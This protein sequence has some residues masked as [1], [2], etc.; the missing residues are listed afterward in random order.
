M[1]APSETQNLQ[2]MLETLDTTLPASSCP[3]FKEVLKKFIASHPKGSA[4]EDATQPG[5]PDLR[6]PPT[7]SL[8]LGDGGVSSHVAGG[9]EATALTTNDTITFD[10]IKAGDTSLEVWSNSLSHWMACEVKA[11]F[12]TAT[13]DDSYFAPA[14]SIKVKSQNGIKYIRE[15]MF[16]ILLRKKHSEVK[17]GLVA[18]GP[19]PHVVADSPERAAQEPRCLKLESSS[20]VQEKLPPAIVVPP[21][22]QEPD[23]PPSKRPKK[24]SSQCA[25]DFTLDSVPG[26]LLPYIE[27]LVPKGPS[28]SDVTVKCKFEVCYSIK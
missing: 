19:G 28:P 27:D 13:E 22:P 6:G 12:I 8:P 4:S 10:S 11:V 3:L 14:R 17:K 15:P 9:D 5:V 2:A 23:V 7:A 18:G 21:R 26:E 24:V 1:L 25:I 16:P 20:P